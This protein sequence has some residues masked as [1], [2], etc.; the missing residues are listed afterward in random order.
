M[1][2]IAWQV[3]NTV[4]PIFFIAFCGFFYGKRAL[5]KGHSLSGLAFANTANIRLFAPAL[6]FDALAYKQFSLDTVGMIVLGGMTVVLGS[7]L[8]AIPLSKW[9]SIDRRTLIPPV[10]FT[11]SGN[12]GIP[13]ILLALGEHMLPAA[14]L[15]FIVEMALHMTLGIYFLNRQSSLLATIKEPMI[16]A[17]ICGLAVNQSGINVPHSVVI[18]I[19]MLGQIAVPLMLFSL[20]VR[21]SETGISLNKTA[22]TGALATPIVGV[23]SAALFLF[24][25]AQANIDIPPVQQSALL[26]FSVLPPAVMNY[27][28]SERFNVAPGQVAS[29]VLLG[30]FSALV[31]IPVM[32]VYL[33]LSGLLVSPL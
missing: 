6:I 32:L 13:L 1:T 5:T 33:H 25:A 4:F 10:M 8:L 26:L 7:G 24:L 28:V 17:A 27:I 31:S 30:N 15:L 21:M 22:I 19:A 20:G 12:L 2:T 3:F 16:I 11:N 9:L 29:I 14:I 23:I 18:P